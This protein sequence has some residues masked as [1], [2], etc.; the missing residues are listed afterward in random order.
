M[1]LYSNKYGILFNVLICIWV[2][3][4]WNSILFNYHCLFGYRCTHCGFVFL[5]L[6]IFCKMSVKK[7]SEMIHML[8][9]ASHVWQNETE[10]KDPTSCFVIC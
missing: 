6:N 2:V 1:N 7:G 4:A 3:R 5:K 10:L 9:L 8:V